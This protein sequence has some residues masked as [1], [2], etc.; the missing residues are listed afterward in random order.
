MWLLHLVPYVESKKRCRIEFT[1]LIS[2]KVDFH[3]HVIV[4]PCIVLKGKV[5]MHFIFLSEARQGVCYNQLQ[6][7]LFN[8]DAKGT[9]PSV[10]FTEVSVL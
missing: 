10:R 9:Q 3:C 6:S 2:V 1:H 5:N 4:S 8:T 7:N